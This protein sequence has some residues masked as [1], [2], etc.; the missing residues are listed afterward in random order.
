MD[1]EERKA[2][3]EGKAEGWTKRRV[4]C[5]ERVR[6]EIGQRGEVSVVRCL[7]WSLVGSCFKERVSLKVVRPEGWETEMVRKYD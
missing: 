2:R 5:D 6:M 7:S 3:T 4:S 1:R